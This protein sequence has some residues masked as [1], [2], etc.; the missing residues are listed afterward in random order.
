MAISKGFSPI[1]WVL[2][3]FLCFLMAREYIS[4]RVCSN[5]ACLCMTK[6][7]RIRGTETMADVG[8]QR[9]TKSLLLH[10]KPLTEKSSENVHYHFYAD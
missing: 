10:T 4:D 3:A 2:M 8:H 9:F 5:L 7:T 1:R 6:I